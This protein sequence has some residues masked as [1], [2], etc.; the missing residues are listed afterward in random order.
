MSPAA[1]TLPVP[2][3][4]PEF[5]AP[6]V[7]EVRHALRAGRREEALTL[8]QTISEELGESHGPLHNYTL[9]ALE[10]VAFC[11]QFA[12]HPAMATEVSVHTAAAWQR[13]LDSEHRQVRRQARNGTASWL[14]VTNASAAVRTGTALLALLQ[15][16][17]GKD[18]PS[19]PFVEHRL[20]AITGANQEAAGAALQASGPALMITI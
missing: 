13:I 16:V 4:V 6:R 17:Y 9:H 1:V 20:N 7:E 11:A 5:L 12:G 15:S 18:H 8:A 2:A 3:A 19:T 14:T 10:L